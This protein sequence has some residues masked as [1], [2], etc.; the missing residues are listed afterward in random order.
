MGDKE[1]ILD[2]GEIYKDPEENE[3]LELPLEFPKTKVDWTKVKPGT[4]AVPGGNKMKTHALIPLSKDVIRFVPTALF[5]FKNLFFAL[6]GPAI[7]VF[8]VFA[9]YLGQWPTFFLALILGISMSYVGY[10]SF[11]MVSL[12][13]FDKKKELYIKGILKKTTI[14]LVDIKAIQLIQEYVPGE[15]NAPGESYTPYNSYEINLVLK[16]GDRIN[17]VDHGARRA[18]QRQARR[19]AKFLTVPLLVFKDD[20]YKRYNIK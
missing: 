2:S 5:S 9:L 10:Y 20:D 4:R 1:N 13:V 3:K 18:A 12:L 16:S 6:C 19:L 11:K 7:I 14:N 17:V 8:S 15:R